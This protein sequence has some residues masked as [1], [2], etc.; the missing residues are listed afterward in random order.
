MDEI[1]AKAYNP[2]DC[3]CQSQYCKFKKDNMCTKYNKRI[4]GTSLCEGFEMD[5]KIN[6]I[7]Y[8][9]EDNLLGGE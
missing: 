3:F 5:E 9:D 4:I 8:D 1:N 6:C 7:Y 2:N